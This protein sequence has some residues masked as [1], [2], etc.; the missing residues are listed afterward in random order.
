MYCTSDVAAKETSI[1]RS[2]LLFLPAEIVLP[3][4]GDMSY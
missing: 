3:R 4:H 1:N 2:G